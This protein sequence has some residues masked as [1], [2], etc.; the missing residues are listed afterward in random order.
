MIAEVQSLLDQYWDWLRDHTNLREIEDGI[1]ITTPYLDRHNDYLQIYAQRDG[2]GFVLTDD[3]YILE[4]LEQSGCKIDGDK[5]VALFQTTLN[6]FGVKI[7]DKALV[8]HTS[9]ED[10]ALR[11]HNLVQAMLAVNDLFYL[12]SP[13]V[14]RL[15]Y[16][17]VVSWLDDHRIRYTPQVRFSGRS[18]YD[19]RFDFVIP[20]STGQPERV[21]RT[22]NRPDRNNAQAVAFLWFDTK[23][24]R[25]PDSRAFAIL[26]DADE[27]VSDNVFVA[28]R[29]YDVSPIAWSQRDAALDE[30]A[31]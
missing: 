23:D 29:N 6:G 17:D 2:D 18:G 24:V 31:A 4:D 25:P 9:S 26:N 16:E 3:G 8:V 12:A 21:V 15:F 5:R 20:K 27:S 10:F 28:M 14:A 7:N 11:K 1:E 30:L 13:R 19:H 22:V